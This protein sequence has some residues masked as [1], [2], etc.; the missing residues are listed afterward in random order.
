[1]NCSVEKIC[2]KNVGPISVH[3]DMGSNFTEIETEITNSKQYL[4]A[5]NKIFFYKPKRQA[6]T[7]DRFIFVKTIS[8]MGGL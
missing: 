3:S 1:M 2:F 7:S 5:E 6:W 4:R 8:R